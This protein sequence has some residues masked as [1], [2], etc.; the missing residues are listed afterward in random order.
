[1]SIS[2][3]LSTLLQPPILNKHI[4][5]SGKENLPY[6]KKQ[7]LSEPGSGQTGLCLSWREEEKTEKQHRQ[8]ENVQ[9][10][11]GF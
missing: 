7:A 1:M 6:N 3:S 2:K 11:C 10:S 4:G 8:K 9:F 5:D